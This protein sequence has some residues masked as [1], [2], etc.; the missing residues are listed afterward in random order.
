MKT[1]L[2]QFCAGEDKAANI[3][4]ALTFSYEAVRKGAKFIL[5]PEIFN[6]RGDASDQGSFAR[7]TEKIPVP[8]TDVFVPLA[9]KH[10]VSFLLGSILEKA[11]KPLP[12]IPRCSLM[13]VGKS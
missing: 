8:T 5:F 4:K 1:A 13:L 2:L 6:F 9:R 12:I 3:A 10:K 11:L 7:V